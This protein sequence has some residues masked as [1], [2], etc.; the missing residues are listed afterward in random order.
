[1]KLVVPAA[2]GVPPITPVLALM[3]KPAGSVPTEMDQL[4]F[5]CHLTKQQHGCKQ[6]PWFHLAMP[7]WK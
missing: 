7:L 5:Q 1:V 4:K 2:D 6:Y 3:L